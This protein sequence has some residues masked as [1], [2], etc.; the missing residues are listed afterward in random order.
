MFRITLKKALVTGLALTFSLGLL[1]S[2]CK[3]VD[4]ES[5]CTRMESCFDQVLAGKGAKLSAKQAKDMKKMATA[6][7]T[8][9]KK[10][11]KRNRGYGRDAHK[12]DACMKE[13]SCARFAECIRSMHN[14]F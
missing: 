4:C 8:K 2:G 12:I 10:H 5:Y 14:R 1:A 7:E 6:Y 11:C 9:C 3:K 13:K